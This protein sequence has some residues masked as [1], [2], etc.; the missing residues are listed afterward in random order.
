MGCRR[1][2]IPGA[3]EPLLDPFLIP[4]IAYA[5]ELKMSCDITTNGSLIDKEKASWFFKHRVRIFFKLDSLNPST[6][7][8]LAQIRPCY[9]RDNFSIRQRQ[10][11]IP[12]GLKYLF[13]A[14]YL[15]NAHRK[16]FGRLLSAA[17]VITHLNIADI[18][19]LVH[20]CLDCGMG[21]YI[22]ELMPLGRAKAFEAVFPGKEDI[23]RLYQH[24]KPYLNF[25]SRF[26]IR[27]RCA[28]ETDPFFDINGDMRSCFGL[29]ESVGNIRERPLSELHAEQLRLKHKQEKLSPIFRWGKAGFRRCRARRALEKL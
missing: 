11:I 17:T 7:D 28:F 9:Q 20:F 14:G 26:W 10:I 21:I 15:G 12:G 4:L 5:G 19:D 13:E 24:I 22:E 3:G 8:N 25:E 27:Y 1:I 18:P 16:G 2:V 23:L 6:Q 29:D